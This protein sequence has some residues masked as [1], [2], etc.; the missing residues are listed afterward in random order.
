MQYIDLGTVNY[1]RKKASKKKQVIKFTLLLLVV[2]FGFYLLLLFLLPG[3]SLKSV[4]SAPGTAISILN[5]PLKQVKST[6]GR[7]NILVLGLDKRKD[8]PYSYKGAGGKI[9]YNGFNTDTMLIASINLST[10]EVALISLPRDIYVEYSDHDIGN[11]RGKI[12]SIYANGQMHFYPGGGLALTKKVVTEKLGL[13]IHYTA[14]VDFEAFRKMVDS[15]GGVDITIDK[16]FDDYEYPIEGKENTDCGTTTVTTAE[17]SVAAIPDYS[18]RYEALHFKSGPTHMDGNTALKFVRSRHGNN[19][20][21]SDFARAARQQK[22][23]VALKNKALSLET[24]LDPIK[25]G[26]LINDFGQTIETDFDLAALPGLVKIGKEFD[27]TKIHTI[28]LDDSSIIIH[29]DTAL[30]GG[31]WVLVPKDSWQAVQKYLQVAITNPAILSPTP[32]VSP[33]VTKKPAVSR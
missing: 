15:V 24:L 27:D 14:R 29:P 7:T 13:Q 16:G 17:G 20:E 4:L 21:G 32:T 8:I 23:I 1:K 3:A 11:L 18:C 2:F 31:S 25:V 5:D 19:N 6:D 22:L 9:T 12:N 28:V 26:S 30:Y 10:K 33:T